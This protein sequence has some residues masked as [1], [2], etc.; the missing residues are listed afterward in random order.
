MAAIKTTPAIGM[1][2]S[3]RSFGGSGVLKNVIWQFSHFA[4]VKSTVFLH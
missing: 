1:Q 4:A 3:A 2:I